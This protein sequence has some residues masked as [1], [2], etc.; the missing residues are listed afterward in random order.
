MGLPSGA[1]AP[2]DANATT[3][4]GFNYV[5]LNSI[6]LPN[7]T[8]LY[9]PALLNVAQI[10]AAA[11]RLDLGDISPNNVIINPEIRNTSLNEY[12]PNATGIPSGGIPAFP[13][14]SPWF[15]WTSP[16]PADGAYI[17]TQYECRFVFPLSW[18][19]SNLHRTCPRLVSD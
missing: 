18:G 12:F 6:Y 5:S 1:Q 19:E 17:L 15:S 14:Y 11:I 9:L 8:A 4:T 16:I 10:F 7:Q 2:F 13:Y 3:S